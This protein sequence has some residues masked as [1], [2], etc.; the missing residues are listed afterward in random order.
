MVDI[1]IPILVYKPTNITGGL[2]PYVNNIHDWWFLKMGMGIHP[3]VT[4]KVLILKWL[5]S[6]P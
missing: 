6:C 1:S 3:V 4:K 2:P 5:S